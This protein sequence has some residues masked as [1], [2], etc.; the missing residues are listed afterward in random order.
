MKQHLRR[1]RIGKLV[2]GVLVSGALSAGMAA[3]VASADEPVQHVASFEVVE[4][5]EEANETSPLT[6]FKFPGATMM[7]AGIRW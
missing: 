4:A 7:R 1:S 3:G 2:G 5:K 6:S